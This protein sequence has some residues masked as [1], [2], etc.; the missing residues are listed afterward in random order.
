MALERLEFQSVFQADN[1]FRRDR[2][3]DR[4]G[5]FGRFRRGRQLSPGYALQS[6]VNLADEIRNFGAGNGIMAHV[7]GDDI[8]GELDVEAVTR[9]LSHDWI[10]RGCPVDRR[11]ML[12]ST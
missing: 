8:C 1:K 7:S 11:E 6:P 10:S 12:A 5:W 4:Y 2:A 3:L 9:I